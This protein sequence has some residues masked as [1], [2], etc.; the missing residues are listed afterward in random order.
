MA[1]TRKT[2]T[3]DK[4]IR[5]GTELFRRNGYVATTVD[6]ICQHADVTKGAFFHH[7]E[8]KEALAEACLVQWDCQ[9]SAMEAAAP[10]QAIDDPLKKLLGSMDFYIG[11][12]ENPKLLKSCLAGTTVQDVSETH[13][14]LR[15][16]ADA[17][18]VNAESRFA[19]LLDAAGRSRG[20]RLDSASLARLWMATLQGALIL[21][22]A[23]RDESV[24]SSSLKHVKEYI[25]SLLRDG[26][27]R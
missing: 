27:S 17:C 9:A 21:S 22:K 4:L 5:A 2:D 11:Q 19:A 10:F 14:T 24:I 3:R 23:S 12:F 18:F 13:P 7:F 15:K 6:E 16:A 25:R 20:K 8:S 1:E 26:S